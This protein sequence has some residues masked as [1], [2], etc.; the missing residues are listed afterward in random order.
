MIL[1]KVIGDFFFFFT[2]SILIRRSMRG[3]GKGKL[4][5]NLNPINIQNPKFIMLCNLFFFFTH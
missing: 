3:G 2:L 4:T 1:N 5:A